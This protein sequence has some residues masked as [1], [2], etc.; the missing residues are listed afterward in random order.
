MDGER[1]FGIG[2]GGPVRLRL[3]IEAVDPLVAVVML[4][5]AL[6]AREGRTIAGEELVEMVT[7]VV[8]EMAADGER[9][10]S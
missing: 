1:G 5:L 9:A 6:W 2:A 8:D 7:A 10:L 4:R 3:T